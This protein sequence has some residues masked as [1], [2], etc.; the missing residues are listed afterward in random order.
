MHV[1]EEQ[2]TIWK[3][4][5]FCIEN[6]RHLENQR[7]AVYSEKKKQRGPT[8]V[9]CLGSLQGHSQHDIPRGGDG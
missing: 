5:L 7:A 8:N 3:G 2:G 4:K 9:E 6:E 1:L